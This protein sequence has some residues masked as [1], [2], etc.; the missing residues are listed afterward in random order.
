MM[1]NHFNSKNSFERT[2]KTCIRIATA[3]NSFNL[4]YLL[5]EDKIQQ[6]HRDISDKNGWNIF[7]PWL[8]EYWDELQDSKALLNC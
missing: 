3:N 2:G 5:V 1:L 8:R 7:M 6:H 4:F